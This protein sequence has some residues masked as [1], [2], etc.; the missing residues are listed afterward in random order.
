M[1]PEFPLFPGLP[2]GPELLVI[3][4]VM[5]LILG[6][7]TVLVGAAAIFGFKFLRGGDDRAERIEELEREVRDLRARL[8]N[9]RDGGRSAGFDDAS[10]A[11]A[12]GDRPS[13]RDV[14]VADDGGDPRDDSGGDGERPGDDRR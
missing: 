12:G 14:D 6:V 11:D 5:I 8:E 4:L 3:L 2:G 13:V 1:V 9:E 7:P 10:N